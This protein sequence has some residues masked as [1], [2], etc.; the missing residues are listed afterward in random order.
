VEGAEIRRGETVAQRL[1]LALASSSSAPRHAR[2]AVIDLLA[3]SGRTDLA[4]DA[5][6]LVSEL[7]TNAVLHAGG[8]IT[9]SAAYV[10]RT[11]RVE[12]H[13]TDKPPLPDLH[14]P[15]SADKT[16]RGLHLVGLLADRWAVTPTRNGKTVWFEIA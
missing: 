9:V 8:P 3:T 6:L 7:V 5:A 12:V 11:L 4:A 1:N 10:D 2:H 15:S 14:K 16:G 13:D